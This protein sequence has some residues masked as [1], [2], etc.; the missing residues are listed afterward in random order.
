VRCELKPRF[1]AIAAHQSSSALTQTQKEIIFSVNNDQKW[2]KNILF[3][4]IEQF[5]I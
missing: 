2:G 5:K 1:A 4:L 3:V